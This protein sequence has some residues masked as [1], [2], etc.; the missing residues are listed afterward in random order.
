MDGVNYLSGYVYPGQSISQA[1][2][3]RGPYGIEVCMGR[4]RYQQGCHYK[5]TASQ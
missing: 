1:N 2:G 3:S 5:V 4:F